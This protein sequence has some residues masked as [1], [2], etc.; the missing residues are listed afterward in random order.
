MVVGTRIR[1][2]PTVYAQGVALL[3][4]VL[5]VSDSASAGERLDTAGPA[6]ATHL[7]QGGFEVVDER[8][9][10]DGIESVATALRELATGFA[11]LIV[12]TGGTGFAPRDLTPEATASV[13]EREAPGFAEVMR[14]TSPYGALSR[15]RCGIRGESLIL[16]TPGSPKAALECLKAVA[17]MLSH[18]LTLLTGSSDAHP[19]ETGG[20]TAISSDGPTA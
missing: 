5:T 17:P 9:V 8:I 2:D 7:T 11:G 15:G 3:A 20:T 10:T 12:T 14:A 18:A 1:R 19:P 6:V 16:N 13:L 4:K